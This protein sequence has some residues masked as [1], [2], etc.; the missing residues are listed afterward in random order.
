MS[1][2]RHPHYPKL[3]KPGVLSG[4]LQQECYGITTCLTRLKVY[5]KHA[6]NAI[7]QMNLVLRPLRC[8]SRVT[9]PLLMPVTLGKL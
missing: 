7:H 2:H 5:R 4:L 6:N 3:L 8:K 9:I 1:I